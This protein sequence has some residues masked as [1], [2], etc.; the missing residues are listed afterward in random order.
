MN[1]YPHME[2]VLYCPLVRPHNVPERA[3]WNKQVL[4]ALG[5]LTEDKRLEIE[6]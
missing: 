1:D 3:W 5:T 6:T 4:T 2:F